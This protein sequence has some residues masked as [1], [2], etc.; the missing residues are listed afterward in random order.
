MVLHGVFEQTIEDLKEMRVRIQRHVQ[1]VEASCKDEE[2]VHWQ[3]VAELQ[4]HNQVSLSVSANISVAVVQC[5]RLPQNPLA[6]VNFK[7]LFLLS[8]NSCNFVLCNINFFICLWI[9]SPNKDMIIII[10]TITN[11]IF[12]T[13]TTYYSKF[14]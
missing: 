1:K 11:F 10:I 9:F 12:Q 3:K 4:K 8:N 6:Y 13:D 2:K 14:G 5:N 7:L